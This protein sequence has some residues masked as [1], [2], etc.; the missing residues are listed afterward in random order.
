VEAAER[1]SGLVP[2]RAGTFTSLLIDRRAIDRHG[3]PD[4]RYFLW[5]DDLEYTARILRHERGFLATGSVVLH[6]TSVPHTAA[7][8]GSDRYYFHVRNT[9]YMLRG[10]AWTSLEKVSHARRLGLSIVSF[11][12]E[13]RFRPRALAIVARGLRD[14][15][16]GTRL[17]HGPYIE[18]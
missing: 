9:I 18:I 2:I 14:G 15:I 12:R 8:G 13:A 5:S 1:R 4:K 17:A 10:S 16:I 7:T 3:L 6:K 11:V